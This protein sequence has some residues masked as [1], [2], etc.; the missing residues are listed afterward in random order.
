[1]GW[2]QGIDDGVHCDGR[3]DFRAT[4]EKQSC[5]RGKASFRCSTHRCVFSVDPHDK[6]DRDIAR[7]QESRTVVMLYGAAL[8]HLTA[9]FFIRAQR[10]QRLVGGGKLI[11]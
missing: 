9:T 7:T 10:R 6:R 5:A 2:G 11:W 8:R 1:M 4:K 3:S